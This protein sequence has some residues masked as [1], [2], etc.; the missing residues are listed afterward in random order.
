MTVLHHSQKRYDNA[1]AWQASTSHPGTGG[2]EKTLKKISAFPVIQALS[3]LM[4]THTGTSQSLSREEQLTG[5][6]S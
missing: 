3:C 2:A 6:I 1:T 4:S 5:I